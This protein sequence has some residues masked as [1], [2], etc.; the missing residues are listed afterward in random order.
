MITWSHKKP[1]SS[2]TSKLKK[3]IALL[4]PLKCD[5]PITALIGQSNGKPNYRVHSQLVNTSTCRRWI[6]ELRSESRG[7]TRLSTPG[8]QGWNISS[9][10]PHSPIFYLIFPK[11][12]FT[13]FLNLV[14]WVGDL[15][16]Q[17]GPDDTTGSDRCL[18][19]S[20]SSNYG[21][22]HVEATFLQSVRVHSCY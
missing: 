2:K 3:N 9:I 4:Y 11:F 19:Q 22:L 12:F 16:I 14:L 6:D 10:C 8:G 15:P 21:E 18:L 1:H 7:I 17:E 20:L 13:F 5:N